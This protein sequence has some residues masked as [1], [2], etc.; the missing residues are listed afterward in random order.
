V[1]YRRLFSYESVPVACHYF[2][3]DGT[4]INAP[5][6]AAL[7]AEILQEKLGEDAQAVKAYLKQSAAIYQNIGTVFLHF[8]LH[9]AAT[10][11]QS[12]IL[13]AIK[14]SKLRYLFS[15]MNSENKRFLKM[16]KL[17][18]CLTGMP[19]ITEVTLIKLRQCLRLYLI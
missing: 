18:S 17:F 4:I 1:K 2:Y 13:K 11:F 19:L 3:E 9:K 15:S 7:L 14:A 6:D 5:A 8:S 10:L 16:K 12:A